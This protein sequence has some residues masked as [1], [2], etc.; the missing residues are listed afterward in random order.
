[1]DYHFTIDF[2]SQPAGQHEN[3]HNILGA[4]RNDPAPWYGFQI[5]QTSTNKNISFGTQFA[6]GNNTN[7]T[8]SPMSSTGN[9]GEYNLKVIYDPT[10][11]TAKFRVINANTGVD[12]V[13]YNNTFPN[14]P[15]LEYIKVTLGYALDGNGDPYRYS[16]INVMD[17]NIQKLNAV[18]TPDILCSA[19]TV[20]LSC[21]TSGADI[22]YRVNRSGDYVLYTGPFAISAITVVDAYAEDDYRQS[23]I[24][25][26]T[27]MYIFSPPFMATKSISFL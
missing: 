11:S 8:I 21:R 4:K 10:A 24:A 1:M 14:I 19:N 22:Y 20:A 7:T 9:V 17:F 18:S 5:R 25:S 26:E 13:S 6:T 3:H 16:N 2:S 27:C 15:E 12:I 23:A